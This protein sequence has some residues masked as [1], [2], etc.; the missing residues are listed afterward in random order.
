MIKGFIQQE[1]ITLVNIYAHNTGA[2]K[3]IKQILTNIKGETDSNTIIVGTLISHLHQ[4]TD[5]PDRKS[6]RKHRP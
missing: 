2:P 6:L 3:Y 4:W 1:D 5:N